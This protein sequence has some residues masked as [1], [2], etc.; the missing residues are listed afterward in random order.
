M[1]GNLNDGQIMRSMNK[2]NGW[3]GNTYTHAIYVEGSSED[4]VSSE[5]WLPDQISAQAWRDF[6]SDEK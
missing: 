3:L 2:D 1:A 5:S 6:V 4:D